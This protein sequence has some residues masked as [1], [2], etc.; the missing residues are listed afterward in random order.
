MSFDLD[1]LLLQVGKPGSAD[2]WVAEGRVPC[3]KARSSITPIAG[4]EIAPADSLF[5]L[6]RTRM[7]SKA[8]EA[9]ESKG[10]CRFRMSVHDLLFRVDLARESQGAV[11]LFRPVAKDLPSLDTLKVPAV[12]KTLLNLQDGLVLF[13]GPGSSGVTTLA[14][15]FAATICNNRNVRVRILDTDPEWV[16]PSGK[17]YVVRGLSQQSLSEDIRSSLIS[18]TD[19][20]LFGD[21]EAPQIDLTLEACAGG[22]LVLANLRAS[23]TTHAVERLKAGNPLLFRSLR[24]IICRHLIPSVD[25]SD[26]LPVWDIL[27]ANYQVIQAMEQGDFQKL[28]QIQKVAS[29]EGMVSLDESLALLVNQGR[30]TKSEAKFRAH[31][32]QLFE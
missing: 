26:V 16:I 32:P 21:I 8:K 13:T 31:E 25:G 9:W 23:S 5:P 14:A 22:A 30:I 19:L 28:P 4:A 11:A 15:S 24:A 1:S 27:L 20:F 2:L 3:K 18:G 10:N 7:D 17:S 12:I 6:L 29:Q